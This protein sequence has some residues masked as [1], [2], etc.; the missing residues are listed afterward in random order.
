MKDFVW[1]KGTEDKKNLTVLFNL[2]I[3]G[4]TSD[5]AKI[6]ISAADN[7]KLYVNGEL[8]MF[9]PARA[10]AGFF[11][12]DKDSL[13][14]G[15]GASI[16]VLVTSYGVGT[17]SHA[18]VEPFFACEIECGDKKYTA[19]DFEAYSFDVKER[20]TERYSFQ[21][22]FAE[23]YIMNTDLCEIIT[24]PKNHLSLLEKTEAVAAVQIERGI[25]QPIFDIEATA[26]LRACGE[27]DYNEGG[28]V[29]SSRFIDAISDTFWGYTREKLRECTTDYPSRLSYRVGEKIDSCVGAGGYALYDFGRN[30]SGFF[31]IDVKVEED[32][33]IYFLF[34][35]MIQDGEW[36]SQSRLDCANVIKWELGCGEYHLESAEIYEL[37]YASVVVRSG[38][39]D[40]ERIR[41]RL[42]ENFNAYNLK[43]EIADKELSVIVEAA[44]NTVAQNGVD[45][46]MD[47][48]SRERSGWINDVF[49]TRH[50]AEIITGSLDI[51]KN[52]LENY[53]DC[54]QLPE[55]PQGMVPMCYPAAHQNGEY[56]PNCAMWYAIIA[57]EYCKKSGDAAF[58]EKIREQVYGIV[59]FFKKYENE[60]SLLES[61]DSWVFVEW[62]QANSRD[63]V[64]GVNFP[65]NM[66][67]MRVLEDVA[68]LY[69]DVDLEEK[70]K[71]MKYAIAQLSF[72]GEFFEDNRVRNEQGE[73]CRT[74]NVSEA[75][76]YHAFYFGIAS[77]D[78]HPALYGKLLKDFVPDRDRSTV[79][80][81]IDKANIITGVMMRESVLAEDGHLEQVL[82]EVKKVFGMMA[83]LTGTLWEHVNEFA[84][85]NHGCASYAAYIIVRAYTGLC[86][87][88]KGEPIFS[89]R[90]L[91]EDCKLSIKTKNGTLS[92]TV[93]DG[94]REWSL[95]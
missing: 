13:E 85:C 65:T 43:L 48:P 91:G 63:F 86:G 79:Y 42:V 20:Y 94:E 64:C 9:G 52:T 26:S 6:E 28:E 53:A 56:I 50:S 10:A 14:I 18:L 82:C 25:D 57:C 67:Y 76:Q 16:S 8:K 95:K 11:R 71:K 34:D 69:G 47:C 23:Y 72:N 37:R 78:S 73:L 24:E 74:G 39:V 58:A 22:G 2:K 61:L 54:G 66:M 35:E 81:K 51:E 21:R 19:A 60:Y 12:T 70:A 29:F 55:L 40:I 27:V 45:L 7:Y 90:Y 3:K 92:V 1:I 59:R 31:G 5:R 80:P 49:F 93:K 62:S 83:S 36:V 4:A 75:C 44:K 88:E 77:R 87:F 17:Y 46:F 84:S 15:E 41:A 30:V 68:A 33:E 89:D 38:R 32:A